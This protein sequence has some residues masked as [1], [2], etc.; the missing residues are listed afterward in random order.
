MKIYSVSEINTEARQAM[1]LTFE[2]PINVKGEISDY[3]QSRG[4]QY[5]KL[6]DMNGNYTVSC[7]MWKGS[8]GN[9]D[10]SQYLDREVI[11]TAKVDFYA[12][13]GQFQ[14]N[15]IELSEF[16]D[17]FLKNEI[18]KIKK[19]L[20]DEGVFS[21]KRSLP[22][23]PKKIAV[24]TAKD[25]HALKDVCSKLNEKY[26]MA[27][28]LI[29]PSTVQGPQAPISLIKQLKKINQDSLAD[30][31]LIVRGGGSLQDLMAF[32]DESLVR[33]ISQSNIPT[34]TGIGH[35]PDITLADYASDS[36]QETPTAAAVHAVPDSQMLKQDIIHYEKSIIKL[37]N[38]II[39]K[40]ENK[41]K[42]N[43][44]IIKMSNPFKTIESLSKDFIQ[45][46][47]ILKKTIQDKI[48]NN[49]DYLKDERTRQSHILRKTAYTLT[50][51]IKTVDKTYKD[52]KKLVKIRVHL[53]DDI[54]FSKK[55]QVKQMNPALLL[56][57]GYAIVRNSNKDIIKSIKGIPN[58][59]E[60]SIQVSDGI[61]KVNR[62]E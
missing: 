7:V 40:I 58:K 46:K 26:C 49:Q 13:F 59:S 4:H 21:K 20:S 47:K 12:G 39:L 35:K 32:N 43:Y 53:N 5:F 22:K 28:I 14:L 33:E 2:Y 10:I 8:Y 41:I 38:N 17:G 57:K 9:I 44:L 54:L 11:V 60:L 23:Y 15:I 56:K 48:L 29:Y 30:V 27:E 3:R 1:L 19:K 25:S 31:I 42:G 36:A 51:Y 34:I 6:R 50:E 61:I 52:I 24:L 16:G 62:K 55:Q 45:R 37:M 18:E